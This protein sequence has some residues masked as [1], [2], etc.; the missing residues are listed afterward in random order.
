MR[1]EW[2]STNTRGFLLIEIILASSVF[3]L[4]LTAFAG[5]FYYGLQS[6]SLAGDR[7]RAVMLAE[8]GQEAVRSIRNANFSNLVDG[9]YGLTYSNN[10]WSF[11]GA[12]DV[13]GI[14]TR[15]VVVTSAGTNRKNVTVTV[16]WQQTP[17]RTGSVSSG[18]RYT[19]WKT[20]LNLGTG[21][22]VNTVIINH[23]LSTVASDF[24]PFKVGTT[25]V[26][27]AS[28]TVFPPG[29][30]T[31]SETTNPNY[32]QTFTGDC[33][34]SGQI[35]IIGTGTAKLCTITNEEKLAYVTLNKTVVNHG[36]TKVASDF[37]PFKVGSTTI[38]LGASTPINSGSYMV[39]EAADAN[40][41]LTF[42]G[43]CFTN[44]S[45]T[46]AS[47]DNKAC[48]LTNEE[49]VQGN[50][51]QSLAGILIYGD[52]TSTVPKYRTYDHVN[53]VFGA[54]TGTFTATVGPT[55]LIR[56]SPTQHLA[57]AGY[58]DITGTLTIMCFDGTTWNKE[59]AADSGGVGNRHRFDI[60]FEKTSGDAMVIFSKGTHIF[61]QLGYKTKAGGTGC[62]A[63]W[64]NEQVLD[65]L[66]TSNDIMYVKLAQDRRAG[67]NLL[68]TTWVDTSEDISAKIWDGNAWVNEPGAVTDNNVEKISRSH[69]IEDMDIEY[70]S[71]SGD[72]M[73][74][75]ANANGNN[76]TNG[77]RYRTCT[78]GVAM[79]TWGNVTT[80]PAF[81]DD[82]TSLDISANPKTD[83]I[84]FAS[85]GNANGDLQLGYWNG[86]GWSDVANVDTTCE[87]PYTASKLVSTGWLTLGSTTRSIIVYSDVS[88]GNINWYTG[89]GGV[90]TRQSDFVPT[91]AIPVPRG[92]MD[93]H[94]NPRDSAQLMYL[95]SAYISDTVIHLYAKRL[96]LTGT[97]TFTWTNSDAGGPLQTKLPQAIS[98]PFSFA[99]WQQ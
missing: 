99:F 60:A 79:C 22:T 69:D 90:F 21:I 32:T 66:R 82:A 53:N 97:S 54:Q 46:L 68:A 7:G 81:L 72:V 35:T 55:W 45:I 50:G 49:I 86:L 41:N 93:I 65:P 59:F 3:I 62:G 12:Q 40:Y 37:A 29:T 9:T 36:R 76:G 31:V 47:G 84:V 15:Q 28:S 92:Y 6:S 33:N 52:G 96:L 1:K 48:S 43:D 95:T 10:T 94:M 23:G 18:A 5:V 88:S 39:T 89:N 80:P 71:L 75:W 30:Y 17:G 44:G 27:L 42:S 87:V 83:E 74:V 26:T 78:G 13:S 77:V 57:L 63:G 8:E 14:F 98:S 19:N 64:G 73:L 56:T 24:A 20:I 25:T 38:T 70:E 85:I 2:L 11:S 4:F 51:S 91:N 16:T 61:G 34:S 58:Y 67:S